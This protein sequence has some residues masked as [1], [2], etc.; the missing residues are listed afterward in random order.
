[1]NILTVNKEW[2]RTRLNHVCVDSQ[3]ALFQ[4]W[5]EKGND[6]LFISSI[7]VPGGTGVI[8]KKVNVVNT[9]SKAVVVPHKE[10]K[11][12]K[13]VNFIKELFS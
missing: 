12:K 2:Y 8:F 10:S 9:E 13:V 7:P 11:R 4:E 1:M 3:V 6:V 5:K